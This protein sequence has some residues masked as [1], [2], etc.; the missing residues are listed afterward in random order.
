MSDYLS[1]LAREEPLPAGRDRPPAPPSDAERRQAQYL[2]RLGRII[3]ATAA[4][5]GGKGVT[6]D[7]RW[8]ERRPFLPY[9]LVNNV[10]VWVVPTSAG[11]RFLWDRYRSH[12]VADAA[13]AAQAVLADT[14]QG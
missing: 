2:R 7:L 1:P 9:L 5:G 14:D 6:C 8:Q 10:T 4:A 13:G 11:P 3:T 12:P